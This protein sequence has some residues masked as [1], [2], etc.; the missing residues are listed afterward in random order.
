VRHRKA[1]SAG[2]RPEADDE[3]RIRLRREMLRSLIT[4]VKYQGPG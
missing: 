1:L 4:L 2:W 3:V